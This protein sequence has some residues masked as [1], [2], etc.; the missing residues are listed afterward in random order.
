MICPLKPC[1]N[2]PATPDM[3]DETPCPGCP[4]YPCQEV[5]A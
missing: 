4:Y 3:A 5:I 1:V 2:C